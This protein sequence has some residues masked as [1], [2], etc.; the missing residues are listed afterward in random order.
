MVSTQGILLFLVAATVAAAIA[1]AAGEVTVTVGPTAGDVVG[2]DHAA[3][4]KAA[5]LLLAKAPDGNGVLAIAEGTYAMDDALH[6]R[7]PMTIRGAGI[8]KTVL[9]KG[10]QRVSKL[11]VE[12]KLADAKL[13]LDDA[14]W[15][16]VGWGVTLRY[17]ERTGAWG[18]VVRTVTAIDGNTITL[19]RP[20]GDEPRSRPGINAA[21]GPPGAAYKAGAVV[22][23]S[24]PLISA[25]RAR[26]HKEVEWIE[27][28]EIEG[29]AIDGVKAQ[30]K[31]MYVDG[32]RNG[33]IY[34]H[35][36]RRCAV[37]RVEVKDFAGDG[38][39]WQLVHDMTVENCLADN[40][41]TVFGMPGGNG[42]GLH[43]GTGS[44]RT[45]IRNCAARGNGDVGLFVCWNIRGGRF[46]NNALEGN[47]NHGISI[48]HD[49]GDNVFAGNTVRRNGHTGVWFRRETPSPDGCTFSGN[50]I[51]DNGSAGRA[52][53][54]VWLVGARRTTFRGNTIRDTRADDKEKTQK[55]AMLIHPSV[56]AATEID[57][58]NKI[59]G[60]IAEPAPA[61]RPAGKK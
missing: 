38:I 21:F 41:G 44:L 10:P 39:S 33:G 2:G 57:P 19:D 18:N 34:L 32:C 17:D 3:L 28:V 25:T 49:D 42:Y 60:A 54:G 53:V 37:R 35:F 1:T 8:G 31:D 24:H 14:S 11:A 12:A 20:V 59:E 23:H 61:S 5:D 36:G 22:Q 56:R 26:W 48:G 15:L 45:V 46:E 29:L 50:V 27:G 55:T 43:P 47:G 4:Q 30:N 58:G 40:N 9:R 52:G 6:V 51:E 13:T 7:G 16:R